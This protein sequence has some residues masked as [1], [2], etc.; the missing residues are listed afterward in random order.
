MEFKK[1]TII[2]IK[3]QCNKKPPGAFVKI[4][5]PNWF[6]SQWLLIPLLNTAKSALPDATHPMGISNT[7]EWVSLFQKVFGTV[8]KQVSFSFYCSRVSLCWATTSLLYH[9]LELYTSHTSLYYHYSQWIS[10]DQSINYRAVGQQPESL[11]LASLQQ[12]VQFTFFILVGSSTKAFHA[13][14]SFRLS[15]Q[16]AKALERSWF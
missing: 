1:N 2:I 4:L 12:A 8:T 13:R 6:F 7:E 14:N 5:L 3:Y 9:Q 15:C 10:K 16:P 11:Q